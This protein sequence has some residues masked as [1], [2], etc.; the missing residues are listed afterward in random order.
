MSLVVRRE[1]SIVELSDLDGGVKLVQGDPVLVLELGVQKLFVHGIDI[2][3]DLL[4]FSEIILSY[5]FG[6]CASDRVMV[7]KGS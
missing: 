7:L 2:V 3:L 6:G 1:Y 5:T 4:N